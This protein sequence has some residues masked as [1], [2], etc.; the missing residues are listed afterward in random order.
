MI[1]ERTTFC[2]AL[3]P[4]SAPPSTYSPQS[5]GSSANVMTA[6][7]AGARTSPICTSRRSM[8]RS[9][10]SAIAPPNSDMAMSGMSSTAPRRPVRKAE[11]VSR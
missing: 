7:P 4:A 11:R 10:R 2:T 1:A 9:K 3:K 5:G 8:R 6:S